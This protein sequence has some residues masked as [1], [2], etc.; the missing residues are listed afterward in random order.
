ML[1][2]SLEVSRY[3]YQ[4]FANNNT[5]ALVFLFFSTQIK[6]K[7]VAVISAIPLSNPD[8]AEKVSSILDTT[9][10]GGSSTTLSAEATVQYI[11]DYMKY[12]S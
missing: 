10:G 5:N 12:K 11:V 1:C 7:L 8:D 9:V 2:D 4:G 6:E 3:I